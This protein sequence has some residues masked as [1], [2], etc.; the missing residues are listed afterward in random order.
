[1]IDNEDGRNCWKK[2]CQVYKETNVGKK[3]REAK[4]ISARGLVISFKVD[5]KILK[6]FQKK[7]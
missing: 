2:N 5:K 6:E 7:S 1:M 4:L 3:R